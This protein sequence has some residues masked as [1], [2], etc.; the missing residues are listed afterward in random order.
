MRLKHLESAL[1]AVQREFPD[2]D[3]SLEQYPSS[4]E[5]AAAVIWTA[6]ERGDVGEGR[7][8]LDLGCGTGM[9]TAAAAFVGSDHVLA[10]DCDESALQ[11]ARENMLELEFLDQVSFLL[12][13]VKPVQGSSMAK[14]KK[15]NNMN[16]NNGGKGR[17]GPRSTATTRKPTATRTNSR[18][19]TPDVRE[20][21][22][23]D[24][25]QDG[26]PL[27][28]AC[29]DTVI[30]NPPFG[31]KDNAGMDLR[32]LKTATR[33]ARRTVYSF[34][35]T[36][37]RAFLKKHVETAWKLRAFTVVAEMQFDIPNTYKF[38]KQQCVNIPV[39]LIRIDI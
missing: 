28:S 31:T 29:V 16:N 1:S 5:L 19:S 18:S 25:D 6:F 21:I 38:H 39:D 24:G 10:L 37:T 34:H 4:P 27:P 17:K 13:Q 33:L 26:I 7:T 35:K 2:P 23:S 22:L 8:V 11:I 9:L 14:D 30:T 3:V 12:A 15:R 20:Q 36:S 32:F